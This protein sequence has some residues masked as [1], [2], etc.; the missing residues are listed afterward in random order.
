M[1]ARAIRIASTLVVVAASL[2][3]PAQ[4]ERPA[5]D[6]AIERTLQRHARALAPSLVTLRIDHYALTRE[7]ARVRRSRLNRARR[8]RGIPRGQADVFERY[9]A[10]ARGPVTGLLVRPGVVLTSHYHVVGCVAGVRI[11]FA[12]GSFA[13]GRVGGWNATLDLAVILFDASRSAARPVALARA[14]LPPVGASVAILATA[15]GRDPLT[16]NVGAVSAHERL[17]GRA[18]QL[19]GCLNAGNSGG[20]VI[21]LDGR[22]VA[23][24]GHVDPL[25]ARGLNSGIGFATPIAQVLDALDDLVAGRH[26]ER[27]PRAFLGIRADSA[28][29]ERVLIE[30]VVDDSAAAAAGLRVGDRLVS[31]GGTRILE[32]EDVLRALRRRRA[33]DTVPVVIERDGEPLT[34]QVTLGSRG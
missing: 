34:V 21:D 9:I 12:D 2:S 13:R 15:W 22:V 18:V 8:D 14:P 31:I 17:D 10:R 23:I 19:D 33:G 20:V 1:S 4:G 6:T 24:V 7:T 27:D 5:L 32:P 16:I 3:A 28:G 29:A 25:G 30:Y 26:V 11:E